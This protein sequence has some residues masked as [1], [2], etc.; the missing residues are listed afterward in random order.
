MQG[1]PSE[2]TVFLPLPNEAVRELQ[3][4]LLIT[5]RMWWLSHCA[6]MKHYAYGDDGCMDCNTCMIDFRNT[7]VKEIVNRL[8]QLALERYAKAQADIAIAR[9]E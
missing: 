6:A 9:N 2:A 4:D 1:R 5:R 3:E 7:P 8:H